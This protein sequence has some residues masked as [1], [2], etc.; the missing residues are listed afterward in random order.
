VQ[1][2][3]AWRQAWAAAPLGFYGSPDRTED[4]EQALRAYLVGN[5]RRAVPSAAG[6]AVARLLRWQVRRQRLD[7]RGAS[8]V[9]ADYLQHPKSGDFGYGP[10]GE[11]SGV[12]RPLPPRPV[13]EVER[14]IDLCLR[15]DWPQPAAQALQALLNS[16]PAPPVAARALERL[17]ALH[18]RTPGLA[19]GRDEPGELWAALA[20][21]ETDT[22]AQRAARY[23]AAVEQLAAGR[24]AAAEALFQRIAQTAADTVEGQFAREHLAFIARRK[25]VQK[26]ETQQ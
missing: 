8:E 26:N 24:A 19:V 7:W 9:L 6:A 10:T 15:R 25:E 23:R 4:L 16:Q 14:F 3:E 2:Y 11:G 1:R 12:R 20:E 5:G 13:A 17:A 21:V 22:D 18:A